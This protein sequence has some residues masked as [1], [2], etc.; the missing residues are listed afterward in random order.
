MKIR[1]KSLATAGAIAGVLISHG[2]FA[3]L[4]KE[5]V[6]KTIE[7][8]SPPWYARVTDEALI[9]ITLSPRLLRLDMNAANS[10]R[11]EASDFKPAR[12]SFP[13]VTVPRSVL[14]DLTRIYSYGRRRDVPIVSSGGDWVIAEYYMAG[15]H[16]PASR[17]RLL[18]KQVQRQEQLDRTGHAV[19]IIDIGWAPRTASDDD[20]VDTSTLGDHP[21]WIRVFRVSP[22]GKKTLVALAWRTKGFPTAPD[23]DVMP[24]DNDLI[25]GLPDGTVKWHTKND[26]LSAND[27]DLSARRLSGMAKPAPGP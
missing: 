4:H 9:S 23:T 14:H 13:G 3:T 19:K 21:A 15:S 22:S 26:F 5:P 16:V 10:I 11:A 12:Y 6:I 7:S 25:F 2:V 8:S 24:D 18:G 1:P 27:I 20:S 17:F